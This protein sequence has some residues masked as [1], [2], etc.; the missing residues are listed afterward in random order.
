[1]NI[2][3]H[4]EIPVTDMHRAMDFY[5]S[6]FGIAFGEIQSIHDS[7]MA[8]FPFEEGRDGASGALAAGPIYKPSREGAVVYFQVPDID[9]ALST[10]L[11]LGSEVLFPKTPLGDTGHVAEVTDSE[12]NRIALMCP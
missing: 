11:S 4:V 9:V 12:G 3:A 10:A 5:S 1:M 7:R 2:I 6:L 8:F